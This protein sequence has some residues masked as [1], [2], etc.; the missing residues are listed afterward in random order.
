MATHLGATFSLKPS[1]QLKSNEG[2]D[3]LEGL[4]KSIHSKPASC[5]LVM[6]FIGP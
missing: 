1:Q 6:V 3:L 2:Q 5:R 4:T